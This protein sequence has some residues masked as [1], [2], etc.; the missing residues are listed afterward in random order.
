MKLLVIVALIVCFLTVPGFGMELDTTQEAVKPSFSLQEDCFAAARKGN[1]KSVEALLCQGFEINTQDS[2]C[3][4]TI[5]NWAVRY[6]HKGLVAF[7]LS[8]GA[9]VTIED[10]EHSVLIWAVREDDKEIVDMLLAHNADPA[11]KTRDGGYT[12]LHIAAIRG[13]KDIVEGLLIKAGALV[14][15]ANYYDQTPLM[16]AVSKGHKEIV[17]L[18][19]ARGS[20]MSMHG[21]NV[22]S[23]AAEKG[24]REI[25]QL[26][27]LCLQPEVQ[28]YLKDPLEYA[29]KNMF[30]ILAKGQTVLM[31]A[32]IFGHS[33]IISLF[34]DY[35]VE[36][37]NA[38]DIYNYSAF[39]YAWKYN[40]KSAHALISLFGEKIEAL[41]KQKHVLLKEELK[42]EGPSNLF[43][44]LLGNE[45]LRFCTVMDTKTDIGYIN[46]LTVEL[47]VKLL[48]FLN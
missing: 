48:L 23:I 37:I 5:L 32:C 43:R 39:D 41:K 17:A 27:E 42:K 24:H 45:A 2:L 8:K 21:H 16:L 33:D 12:A 11:A 38:Q 15:A 46:V 14:N 19:L 4:S 29:Q 40:K 7:L 25:V 28:V 10:E 31:L 47:F 36:Y 26:L 34:K 13:R 6:K 44:G 3:N 22:L 9:D 30:T 35:P 1:T 20:T 18:L